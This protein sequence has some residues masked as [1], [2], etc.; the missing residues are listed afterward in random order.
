MLT[1]RHQALLATLAGMTVGVAVF[2][3]V[4]AIKPDQQASPPPVVNSQPTP[5]PSSGTGLQADSLQFTSQTFGDDQEPVSADVPTGWKSSQ[6]GTRPRYL[7]P[8]GVWQVRFDA[9]GSKQSPAQQVEA[10]V[11]SID[12]QDLN[13]I[14]RDNGTLIYT[15]V[16]KTRGPR[17]GLSRFIPADDG[18]RTAMEITVGGRP[19]DEAGLRAVLQRATD[20]LQIS[21][22]DNRPS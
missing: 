18:K 22:S 1:P 10:R 12:E 19:E 4:L 17:M 5:K 15:Y 6:T 14:S 3:T 2:G 20:T 16:D 8:T 7:D 11:K 21:N 9:R 13:V